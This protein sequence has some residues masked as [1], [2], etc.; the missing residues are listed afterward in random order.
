MRHE[1]GDAGRTCPALTPGRREGEGLGARLEAGP[2]ASQDSRA[3]F[4]KARR[5]NG[6]KAELTPIPPQ[7]S[8]PPGSC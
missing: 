5:A 4:L 8:T 6:G 7:P 2:N 1:T 3:L